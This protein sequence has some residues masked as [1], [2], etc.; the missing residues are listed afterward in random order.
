MENP[1]N[2]C[3]FHNDY[4]LKDTLYSALHAGCIGVGVDICLANGNLVVS[5]DLPGRKRKI[6]L[7][8]LNLKPLLLMLE[9]HNAGSGQLDQLCQDGIPLAG[10][11]PYD[12][13]QTFTLVLNFTSNDDQLWTYVMS[14]LQLLQ[15]AGYLGYF[16]G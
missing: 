14:Y 9:K 8:I 3:H 12:T 1:L 4:W 5:H 15:E 6:T 2:R 16:D 10:V 13:Y 7:D 11:F